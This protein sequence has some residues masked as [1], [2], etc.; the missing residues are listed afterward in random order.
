[1]FASIAEALGIPK[2]LVM[3][4]GVLLLVAFLMT[5]KCAYD[6]SIIHTHDTEIEL[7]AAIEDRKADTT[8]AEQTKVDEARRQFEA[9]QL[10]KAEAN[11]PK[12]PAIPD[13]RE[14]ALAFHRCLSLQ[15]RARA[16]GLEP[17]ACV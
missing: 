12:D 8:A 11:A 5:G 7:N 10:Q 13:D 4:A 6:K 14:R 16:N 2:A 3:G 9:D 17:P 15:Q 1:M